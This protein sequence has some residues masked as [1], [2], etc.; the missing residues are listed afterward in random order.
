MSR[1]KAVAAFIYRFIVGDDAIVALAVVAALALAAAVAALGLSAWWVVPIAVVATL[2]ASLERAIRTASKL[3][4]GRPQRDVRHMRSET[5]T[6]RDARRVV[7]A[8]R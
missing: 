3:D 1:P 4:L 5:Q 6:E 2:A 7:G 8:A